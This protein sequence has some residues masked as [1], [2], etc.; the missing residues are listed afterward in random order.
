MS[1]WV[2]FKCVLMVVFLLAVDSA[3]FWRTAAVVHKWPFP[4]FPASSGWGQIHDM[5]IEPRWHT[6]F[7][8]K[9]KWQNRSQLVICVCL[10]DK[11][12]LLSCCTI[13]S[14]WNSL[15]KY[16]LCWPEQG[17]GA[18]PG[19]PGSS[20]RLSC[21]SPGVRIPRLCDV[22]LQLYIRRSKT[23]RGQKPLLRKTTRMF[24]Y[25][26][27]FFLL[28]VCMLFTVLI[29][30]DTSFSPVPQIHISMC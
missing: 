8:S 21:G 30:R 1:N 4:R 9:W 29:K 23:L 2:S 15:G 28:C 18:S 11:S 25:P 17:A 6:C 20:L 19:A 26:R 13:C 3:E 24:Q 5:S 27:I 16:P 14:C 10:G 22:S 7:V 12:G